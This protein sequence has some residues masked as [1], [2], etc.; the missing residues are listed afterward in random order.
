MIQ[1]SSND[2]YVLGMPALR[3]FH[4]M[5]D[6]S[7][8][9]VGFANKIRNFGA[10]IVGDNAPGNP[11]PWYK[12]GKEDGYQEPIVVPVDNNTSTTPGDDGGKNSTT[13]P[14]SGTTNSSSTPVVT[15][16]KNSSSPTDV[17]Q[18]IDPDDKPPII[19]I[20]HPTINPDK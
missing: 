16:P 4:I 15:P 20:N 18:G 13:A 3:A 5:L 2:Q 11:R 14:D 10:E 8:N 19:V 17:D 9:R 12:V 7:G 1:A 6:Y